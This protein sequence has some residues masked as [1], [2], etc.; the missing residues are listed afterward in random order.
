[1]QV[2][3]EHIMVIVEDRQ[4]VNKLMWEKMTIAV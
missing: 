1:M 2:R 4:N 3:T